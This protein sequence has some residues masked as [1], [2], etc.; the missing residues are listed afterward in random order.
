MHNF[1]FVFFISNYF[2][3]FKEYKNYADFIYGRTVSIN[4]EQYFNL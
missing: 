2:I 4:V 1:F 3:Y